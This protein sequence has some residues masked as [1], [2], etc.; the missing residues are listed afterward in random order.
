MSATFTPYELKYKDT[1]DQIQLCS[2]TI[3]DMAVAKS[4]AEIRDIHV[5]IELM[6]QDQIQLKETYDSYEASSILVSHMGSFIVA[7]KNII[8]IRT[9][10]VSAPHTLA[11][12]MQASF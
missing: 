8:G 11:R 10:L 1:V 6:Q 12:E 2:R 4:Q 5:S 3:K 7:S 9:R